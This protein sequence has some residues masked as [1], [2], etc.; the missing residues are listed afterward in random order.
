MSVLCME[1]LTEADLRVLADHARPLPQ[2]AQ[3][4]SC[5]ARISKHPAAM[6]QALPSTPVPAAQTIAEACS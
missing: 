4:G 1:E 5:V 6:P 3:A 2:P